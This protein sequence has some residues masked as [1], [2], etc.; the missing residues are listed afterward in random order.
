MSQ[1]SGLDG[2]AFAI[3]KKEWC[4]KGYTAWNSA[5][6]PMRSSAMMMSVFH[7]ISSKNYIS[8]SPKVSRT[9]LPD[10]C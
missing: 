1:R 8:L 7:R 2:S 9:C 3:A 4:V 10:H 5:G 6:L